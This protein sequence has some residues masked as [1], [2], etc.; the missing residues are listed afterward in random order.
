MKLNI[1]AMQS[2]EYALKTESINLVP[3]YS[4][5]VKLFT[6]T[7][8]E[9]NKE[10]FSIWRNADNYYD[11]GELTI[12]DPDRAPALFS[13]FQSDLKAAIK[14]QSISPRQLLKFIDKR[15]A[16]HMQDAEA[17]AYSL[18]SGSYRDFAISNLS[19][20]VHFLDGHS[21]LEIL[22]YDLQADEY[23]LVGFEQSSN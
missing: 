18:P 19:K 13:W 12:S 14:D 6:V 8:L 5:G 9:V 20:S 7:F 2:L 16:S 4:D 3:I 21:R 1:L 10:S 23:D 22:G 11:S 15:L 17:K